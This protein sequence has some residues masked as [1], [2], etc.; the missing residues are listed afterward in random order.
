ME[1]SNDNHPDYPA[2]SICSNM[3]EVTVSCFGEEMP[4]EEAVDDIFLQL[5][6]SINELHVQIRQLCM[7]EDRGESYQEAYTYQHEIKGHV[8]EGCKMLKELPKVMKQLLPA[9]PKDL[10][11]T[12]EKEYTPSN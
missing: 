10:P 9:R 12:F 5:Q 7:T 11:K 1:M 3:S 4:L 8:D 2:S 6:E